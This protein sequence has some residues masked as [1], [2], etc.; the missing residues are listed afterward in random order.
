MDSK[1]K[2]VAEIFFDGVKNPCVR[3]PPSGRSRPISLP[4]GPQIAKTNEVSI[5]LVQRP[6]ITI[7]YEMSNENN[8]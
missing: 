1:N 8:D 5:A 7:E 6:P 3:C 4:C 2:D